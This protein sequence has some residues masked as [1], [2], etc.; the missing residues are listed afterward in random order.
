MDQDIDRLWDAVGD[1]QRI[2]EVRYL[3]DMGWPL[4]C[5]T[6]DFDNLLSEAVWGGFNMVRL[7]IER[8]QIHNVLKKICYD[9]ERDHIDSLTLF[10]RVLCAVLETDR[11]YI[12]RYLLN[13]FDRRDTCYHVIPYIDN[14]DH[15]KFIMFECGLANKPITPKTKDLFDYA[16]RVAKGAPAKQ[17]FRSPFRRQLKSLL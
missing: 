1:P 8:Y 11:L 10:T 17:L 16:M 14:P 3:L 13:F 6:Q 5:H 15:A 4:D 2:N 7:L 12:G 9:G